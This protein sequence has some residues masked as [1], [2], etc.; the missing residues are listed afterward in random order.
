VNLGGLRTDLPAGDITVGDLLRVLPFDNAL[1]VVQMQG[2]M[3]RQIFERKSRRG[4][5]GIA[6]YGAQVVVDP[7]APEGERVRE[8]LVGGK[9]VEPD[10]LYRVV[11]TDYL[12]EGNSGLDFLAQIP[13]DQVEY[14]QTLDRTALSRYLEKHSPVGPRAD[15][16]WRERKGA[17]QAPYLRHSTLP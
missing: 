16:R 14:T 15:D 12:L 4:S 9:P 10:K 11:T 2:R 5:S 1:V 7:D 17:P 6:Q 13:P 3:I 8:L